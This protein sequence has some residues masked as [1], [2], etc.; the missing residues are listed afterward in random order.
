MKTMLRRV[1]NI[2]F[3]FR[4]LLN[5]VSALMRSPQGLLKIPTTVSARELHPQGFLR[6]S[7]N[8]HVLRRTDARWTRRILHWIPYGGERRRGRPATRWEDSLEAYARHLVSTHPSR[9]F[10]RKI[11]MFGEPGRETLFKER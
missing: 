2:V 6:P 4:T 3:T 9:K 11:V 7:P 8:F 5:M 1:L 10:Y